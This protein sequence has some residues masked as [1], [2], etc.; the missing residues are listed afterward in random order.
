MTFGSLHRIFLLKGTFK[1][2]L[3]Y[4][5]PSGKVLMATDGFQLV[6]KWFVPKK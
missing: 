2:L 1:R 5:V 4:S 6:Q 3:S